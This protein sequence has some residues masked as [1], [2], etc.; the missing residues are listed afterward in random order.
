MGRSESHASLDAQYTFESWQKDLLERN[1][2]A[3]L[4]CQSPVFLLHNLAAILNACDEAQ[5][6]IKL[7]KHGV[8][9]DIGYVLPIEDGWVVRTRAFTPFS[10]TGDED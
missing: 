2:I 6:N 8:L 9:S 10:A 1:E 4:L 7:T 5:M 3:G